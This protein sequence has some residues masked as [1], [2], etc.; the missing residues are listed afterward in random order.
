LSGFSPTPQNGHRS[1]RE[2]L[3]PSMAKLSCP[4]K[5]TIWVAVIGAIATIAVPIINHQTGNS[6]SSGTM[7]IVQ[8][9]SSI[10]VHFSD[11]DTRTG[12]HNEHN[13]TFGLGSFNLAISPPKTA[14]Y[15]EICMKQSAKGKH[16]C[17]TLSDPQE[18]G[19]VIFEVNAS[20]DWHLSRGGA[21]T[22]TACAYRNKNND[23][24]ISC[25]DPH[26]EDAHPAKEKKQG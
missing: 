24:L 18:S 8:A 3:A 5:A 10:E 13:T 4:V 22:F 9:Q 25:S 21:V 20:E 1:C 16:V 23:S 6:S 19:S 17:S 11:W 2:R 14:L 12:H 15:I 7:P 26:V